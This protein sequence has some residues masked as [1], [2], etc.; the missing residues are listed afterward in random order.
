L[1]RTDTYYDLYARLEDYVREPAHG[2]LLSRFENAPHGD[3]T[4]I[5]QQI[6][7]WV[8]AM[9]DTLAANAFRALTAIVADRAVEAR[10]RE[11]IDGRDLGDPETVNALRYLEGCLQEAMRLWPT[12]PLLARE[13]TGDTTLV[14]ERLSEGTQ[15]MLLN[16]F[17]HRQVPDGARMRPERW[18]EAERDYRFNHLSHGTQDCPGIPLV[19]L[20]GKAAIANVLAAYRLTLERPELK[21]EGDLPEMLDFFATEFRVQAR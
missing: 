19:L 8:F 18:P 16:G 9:R 11:E 5:V 3:R 7:H 4:R 1:K 6:P 17:N 15:V 20:L 21:A 10:V 14:G 13:V 12:T 2:S